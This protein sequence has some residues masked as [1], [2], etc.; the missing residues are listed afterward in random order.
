MGIDHCWRSRSEWRGAALSSA[1]VLAIL[2]QVALA[3]IVPVSAVVET[4]P[5]PHSDD[6]ADDPAIWVHPSD[7]ARSLIIGADKQGGIATYSLDGKQVDYRPDGLINNVD[8]RYNFLLGGERVAVLAAGNRTND[9]IAVWKM[10]AATNRLE[11]VAKGSGIPAGL[12]VYGSCLYSSPSGKLYFFVNDKR[13]HVRQF[14]LYDDAGKVNGRLVRSLK[15]LASQVEGCVADDELGHFYLGEES[16][17][18]WKYNAEPDGG[19][20]GTQIIFVGRNNVKKHVEGLAIYYGPDKTGYLL[21]SSQGNDSYAVFRREADNAYV[22]S[23]KLVDGAV[24][25]TNDTDGID[26][27]NMDLGGQFSHG[28]FVA[29][30]GTNTPADPNGKEPNQ[31]FKLVPWASIAKQANPKLMTDTSFDVRK[32]GLGPVPPLP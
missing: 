32:I 7:P 9:T 15:K 21:V 31:N 6:A 19:N 27:V 11:P 24:D 20:T 25:G 4:D 8:L 26:V 10:N 14:E 22:M 28:V 17:G 16:V 23:F 1:F 18:V 13:G 5:V 3:Q 12:T 30:D 2:P 29:Q